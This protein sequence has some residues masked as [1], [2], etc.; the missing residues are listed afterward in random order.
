MPGVMSVHLWLYEE[1]QE[2]SS[3]AFAFP[4]EIMW[5]CHGDSLH[6]LVSKCTH[7]SWLLQFFLEGHLVERT[8]CTLPHPQFRVSSRFFYT[9]SHSFPCVLPK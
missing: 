9:G 7:L 8:F 3:Q 5:M 6:A 1:N 4:T 2:Y